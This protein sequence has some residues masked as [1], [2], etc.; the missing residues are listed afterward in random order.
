MP[1][2]L[3]QENSF[4]TFLAP[5]SCPIQGLSI[6]LLANLLLPYIIIPMCFG[7]LSMAFEKQISFIN[8]S[9]V[10]SR[11]YVLASQLFFFLGAVFW[12]NFFA[13]YLAPP[14]A[15]CLTFPSKAT[16]LFFM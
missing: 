11:Y 8:I 13:A 12:R 7:T 1:N 6:S 3:P 10:M 5:H 2:S 14:M 16:S 9:S 15:F 4:S